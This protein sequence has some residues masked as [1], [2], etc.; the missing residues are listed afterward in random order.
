MIISIQKSNQLRAIA[1]LMMLCL[2]LFNKNYR[3]LFEPLVFIGKSPLSY[4]LSLFCD[5]CVPIFAFVSGYGLYFKYQIDKKEYSKQNFSRIKK[6]YINYWVVLFL[7]AVLLGFIL[8]KD[9]YPGDLIKFILN[10][11]GLDTSYNGAWWFFTIYILFVLTSSFWFRLLDILNPYFYILVLLFVYFLAF[12]F[13]V[14]KGNIF[15]NDLL[16]WLYKN[17]ALYFCTLIQFML[18]AFMLK[19]N[20]NKIFNHYASRLPLKNCIMILGIFFLIIIH[21][22]IPNFIIAPLIGLIFIFLFLEIDLPKPLNSIFNFLSPH[23]TNLWLTH[24]FFYTIYFS[25]FIY[26]F[27]YP[28]LIFLVLLL[29]CLASSYI[30]NFL[31]YKIQRRI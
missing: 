12:Y 10:G 4:Y 20:W 2:H 21:A 19:Y 26:S 31:N 13:R 24:M 9:G 22:I 17:S 15:E 14:Y 5:A 28:I 1:I 3:G 6:L 16:K 8:K 7:F 25:V 29:V 11:L 23:S 30:I 27:K 18:G